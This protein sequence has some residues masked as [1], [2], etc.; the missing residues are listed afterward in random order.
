MFEGSCY[1]FVHDSPQTWDAANH[2]C[3]QENAHLVTVQT[4]QEL[5]FLVGVLENYVIDADQWWASGKKTVNGNWVWETK[6]GMIS[7]AS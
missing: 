7:K 4:S 2:A 5:N 3:G 1:Q 6:S